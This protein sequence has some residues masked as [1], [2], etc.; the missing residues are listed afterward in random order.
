MRR[1]LASSTISRDDAEL[2]CSRVLE[3]ERDLCIF[4]VMATN[5][6]GTVG[7]Y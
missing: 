2:A 3:E 5:D 7:A 4:D 1:R 6:F